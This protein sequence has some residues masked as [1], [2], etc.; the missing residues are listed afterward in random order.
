MRAGAVGLGDAGLDGLR[1]AG[2]AGGGVHHE[3]LATRIP[4]AARAEEEAHLDVA[5]AAER[6]HLVQS[7]VR[8]HHHARPLRYA[9]DAD[10]L[11]IGLL[12]HRAQHPRPLDARDLVVMAAAVAEA[13]RRGGREAGGRREADAR[14]HG[15]VAAAEPAGYLGAARHRASLVWFT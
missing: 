11:G 1:S 8:E 3:R 14:E 7:G 4:A 13:P 6:G 15:R 10:A 9:V 12:E 5:L 2:D